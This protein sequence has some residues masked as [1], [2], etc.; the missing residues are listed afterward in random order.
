MKKNITAANFD[1]TLAWLNPDREQAGAK[2][3]TIRRRLVE[4][5]ASRGCP[6]A[7]YW[8]DETIDRVVSKI[9]DVMPGYEGNPAYYFYGVAK[10][11]YLECMKKTL[12][13][14]A[15]P[16][17]QPSE[18][19]EREHECLE[20]CM[21]RL[22]EEDRTVILGYYSKDG[23]EKIINRNELAQ[24]LGIG[25]NAL[26]IRVYRIRIALKVCIEDCLG[27]ETI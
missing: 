1:R 25:L 27:R 5:L 7:D 20:G 6:D 13:P 26:R 11:I 9:D 22:T 19:I 14:Y 8:A 4:I 2:L 17:A 24:K 23:R 3:E 12:H 16:P 15:P 10:K 21:V 18:D